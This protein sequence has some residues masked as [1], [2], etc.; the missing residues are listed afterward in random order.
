[1][2]DN[3]RPICSGCNKAMGIKNMFDFMQETFGRKRGTGPDTIDGWVFKPRY[4]N[5]LPPPVESPIQNA[6]RFRDSPSQS[7][8]RLSQHY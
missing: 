5:L 7:P 2:V 6:Q 3:L 8:F 1:M 4:Q